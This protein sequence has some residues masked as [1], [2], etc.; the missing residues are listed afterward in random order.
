MPSS[1]IIIIGAGGGGNRTSCV[2]GTPYPVS[3]GDAVENGSPSESAI[4]AYTDESM[5]T[6]DIYL[7]PGA[8]HT[9]PA[10]G[11]IVVQP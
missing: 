6:D 3:A 11:A 1:S 5:V 2:V 9:F 4:V 7:G 8:K 10:A